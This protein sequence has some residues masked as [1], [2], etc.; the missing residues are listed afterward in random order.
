MLPTQVK[1][2]VSDASPKGVVVVETDDGD[3]GVECHVG[4]GSERPQ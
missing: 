4:G 3:G 1:S 2:V